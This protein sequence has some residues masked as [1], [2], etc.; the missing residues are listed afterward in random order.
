MRSDQ[1]RV[2]AGRQTIVVEERRNPSTDFFVRPHVTAFSGH[3]PELVRLDSPPAQAPP[4]G[5]WLVFSRYVTD[6]WRRWV[7]RYRDRIAGVSFF[8][9]DDLFDPAA[10][11]G[12]PWRYRWKLY[13]LAGRHQAWLRRIGAELLVST[14]YLAQKY[15]AWSPTVLPA[16]SPYRDPAGFDPDATRVFYHG[17]ASH[18]AEHRWLRPVMAAVLD[19]VPSATFEVI[20]DRRVAR[21]YEGLS[22]VSVVSP[23]GWEAYRAFV[24]RPGRAVG[25]APLLPS[26]FNAARAPTKL[27]DITAAGAVGVYADDPVYRDTVADGVNG[28]LCP[29]QPESWVEAIVAL[30]DQPDLRRAAWEAARS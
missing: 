29:M 2:T 27:L 28:R 16:V 1:P 4:S 14:P 15:A 6:A 5:V 23:M 10:W 26:R 21:A 9:D 22:G 17:S 8:M 3:D 24:T 18:L 20:G 12:L 19:R 25:V 7:T 13:R 11:V 30:L